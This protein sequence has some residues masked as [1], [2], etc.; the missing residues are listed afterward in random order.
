MS[1]VSGRA[2]R[3]NKQGKVIIQTADPKNYII[4]DV[5]QNDFIHTYNTQLNERHHFGYPPFTRLIR[6]TLK[7]KDKAYLD[8]AADYFAKSLYAFFMDRIIGPE[9]PLINRVNNWYQK[10]ILLKIERQSSMAE[11]KEEI[12]RCMDKLS[13]NENYRSVYI[14]PDVDPM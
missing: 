8:K 7:H 3:K 12:I 1:Q 9:Y 5:I 13:E 10:T 4:K 14:Q 2:G 11:A 6:L